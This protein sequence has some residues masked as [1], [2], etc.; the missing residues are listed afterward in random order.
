MSMREGYLLG[1]GTNLDPERN[2]LRIVERL[3]VRFGR[4][5]LSRL[6]ATAPV[7]MTSERTFLNFCAFAATDLEPA[8]MKALCVGIEVELGRDR[9]HPGSKTRDRPADIDLQIRFFADGS[10]I[11]LEEIPPYLAVPAAEILAL[12]SPGEPVPPAGA[13]IC[14]L[15]AGGLRLGEAPAAVDRDDGTG[16]VVVG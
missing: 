15:A 7:G 12:L 6:Y 16:L 4:I 8:A 13:G 5:L 2:A 11:V 9:S 10:R 3:V 1:I 14:V